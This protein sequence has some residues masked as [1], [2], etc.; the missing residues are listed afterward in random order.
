MAGVSAEP[1]PPHKLFILE[2][3]GDEIRTS[4]TYTEKGRNAVA[5]TDARGFTTTNT[6][7][8]ADRLL[9]K[10]T[11]AKGN[12][13]HYS[14]NP[15]NDLLT[16]IH[17][18]VNGQTIEN[19]YTYDS[20]D[21]L[22]DIGHN[23][24]TYHYDYDEFGNQTGVSIGDTVLEESS[25]LPHNGELAQTTYA[26]GDVLENIYD[27]ELRLKEQKWN[28]SLSGRNTYDGYGNVAVHEDL[29]NGIREEYQYDLIGRLVRQENS[30][31]QAMEIAYDGKN[32][33][34]SIYQKLEIKG[35]AGTGNSAGITSKIK[36]GYVYGKAEK[37]QSPGLLYGLTIDGEEKISYTYDALARLAAKKLH[38]G[39]GKEWETTY[40]YLKGAEEG[41]T[42]TLLEHLKSGDDTLSYTYDALG[43][44]S[45]IA[46][47]GII[48]TGYTYDAL[49]Q[50]IRED[51]RLEDKTI[52]YTYDAGGNLRTRKTYGYTQD[53]TITGAVLEE[54]TYTYGNTRWKDQLTAYD[55]GTITYDAMG[56][57]LNYRGMQMEWQH[58]RELKQ[59]V[60][61]G[62]TI[63]YT[64]DEEGIRLSKTAG[65]TK[66]EYFLNGNKI[67]TMKA[68]T[69]V[70][71]FIYDADGS[72]FSMRLN[73]EDYYYLHN[74]QHDITGLVDS[75]GNRVVSYQ[76]DSW[77]LQTSMTDS[78]QSK[79]GSRN[80]FR[81]REYFLDEETGL[82]YLNSRY[83]DPECGRFVNVD[84]A[85][86]VDTIPATFSDKNLYVYCDNNPVMRKDLKGNFWVAAIAA[87]LATQYIS[88]VIDNVISGKRSIDIFKPKS[89]VGEYIAA[90]VTAVIPGSGFTASFVRNVINEGIINSE[91]ILNDKP[92]NLGKSLVKVTLG[93]MTDFIVD[94]KMNKIL[95]KIKSKKPSNFP[96]YRG[97]Q[98]KKYRKKRKA[99][100]TNKKL[101]RRML[102]LQKGNKGL[103]IGLSFSINYVRNK[104]P[105]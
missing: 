62:C 71:H 54:H 8:G 85:S 13:T 82:Y 99:M 96:T 36:T 74:G 68:G 52:C 25:Y 101:Y 51:N 49:S 78:T 4:M 24:F 11:D 2:E 10:V 69:D 84:C 70:M 72:L 20:G 64:Y 102:R 22:S 12:E 61:D 35:S 53:E 83:Y 87:G 59:L 40:R 32:R 44:I 14:Y 57:P 7:D 56:N 17:T 94:E 37:Q 79:A 97:N 90:G 60:K 30:L 41:T 38:L 3:A 89:S 31:G 33:V 45:T 76:Y 88:D 47:N 29:L 5:I 19:T 28:G 98:Y 77:G 73:G 27:K 43:N 9:T 75:S 58:G 46:E 23:G 34:E 16:R 100:P 91:K 92:C 18:Q 6:Y 103:R 93:T 42:T 65:E 95:R 104:L 81:Y 66:E 26:N 48:K 105:W 86:L 21:R 67:V 50:L 39:D 15:D 80:P 55:G 1:Y 63:R